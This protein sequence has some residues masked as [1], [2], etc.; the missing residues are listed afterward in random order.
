MRD[1]AGQIAGVI[2]DAVLVRQ[3]SGRVHRDRPVGKLFACADEDAVIVDGVRVIDRDQQ[4][5]V[6]PVNRS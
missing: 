5:T 6:E 4:V 3:M 1:V 2:H